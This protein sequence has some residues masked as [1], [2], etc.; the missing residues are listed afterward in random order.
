MPRSQRSKRSRKFRKQASSA[1]LP[2]YVSHPTHIS[3]TMGRKLRGF[4]PDRVR[5]AEQI[6]AKI[7]REVKRD[8]E[9]KG[10]RFNC[11]CGE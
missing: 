4:I 8:A 10:R 7:Q 11:G 9:E 5:T 2:L 3:V 1:G 6:W